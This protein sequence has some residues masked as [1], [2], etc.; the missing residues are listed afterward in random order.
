L[1]RLLNGL[2]VESNQIYPSLP[3]LFKIA[4]VLS[5]E[6]G[7]FF[8]ESPP[9]AGQAVFKAGDAKEI[10]IT[11]LPKE[12]ISVRLLTPVDFDPKAEPYL[13]E[14]PA[15]QS[16]PSHF[17]IHK[18]KE[19]G[20]LLSGKLQMELNKAV[21]AIAPGDLIYLTSDIPTQWKN[22]G[23]GPARLLWFKIK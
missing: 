4:E 2:F 3:A 5:V 13:I 12:S 21:Y 10:K 16:L 23:P 1:D 20:Y 11:D 8:Q 22:P 6:A 18:G 17:F 9:P 7:A 19:A 15:N 14:I